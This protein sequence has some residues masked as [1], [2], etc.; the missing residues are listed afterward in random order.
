M[1]IVTLTTDLG[2][3]D[4]YVAIIKGA[5]LN[6]EASLTM[7]DISHQIKTYDIVQAAFLFR[8]AWRSFPSGTIHLLGVNNLYGADRRFLL[9]AREGHY[10]IAPDNGLFSLLFSSMPDTV[11]ALPFPEE[12]SFP[13]KT[14]FSRA[15]GLL[16]R[17]RPLAEIGQ[18]V[19][20]LVERI[21]FQPVISPAR[22]RGAVIH[23]D[24]YENVIINISRELF[25]Q[26]GKNRS[27]SLFFKR[28]DPI[29][30]L[31][32]HYYDVPVGEL[33]CLFN[34]AGFLEIAINMGKAG[35]LLGLHVEDTIQIDFH[36]P[37]ASGDR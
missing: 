26:V 17:K 6:E 36:D 18:A 34:S 14:I 28:H 12:E 37:E 2:T 3:Q 19:T 29:T 32:R 31:S 21:T 30:Q 7:V 27:F 10:F 35:S 15:V 9:T 5:L 20:D 4:Y 1:P 23:I 16:L 25:Q 8:N 11:Y 33:L 13:L 22:I 24:H